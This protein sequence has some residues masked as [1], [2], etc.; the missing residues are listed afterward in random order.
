MKIEPYICSN[1]IHKICEMFHNILLYLGCIY[2]RYF[3]SKHLMVVEN[4]ESK[5]LVLVEELALKS[6]ASL[7]KARFAIFYGLCWP[8]CLSGS[9]SL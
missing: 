1:K 4:M 8:V 2:D 6:K 3:L 7:C 5:S 9:E